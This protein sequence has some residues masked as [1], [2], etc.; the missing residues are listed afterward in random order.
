VASPV[1]RTPY[2]SGVMDEAWALVTLDLPLR[3]ELVPQRTFSW[4]MK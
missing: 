1:D 4:R 2:P 3:D